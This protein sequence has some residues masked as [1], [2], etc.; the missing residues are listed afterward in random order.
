[1]AV[2]L[3]K[4]PYPYKALIGIHS[5]IDSTKYTDIT[6]IMRFLN[7]T[8]TTGLGTGIGLPFT[9]SVFGVSDASACSIFDHTTDGQSIESPGHIVDGELWTSKTLPKYIKIGWI[10]F[11]HTLCASANSAYTS[12]GKLNFSR[13]W[14][15]AYLEWV[16]T[17]GVVLPYWI[18]HSSSASNITANNDDRSNPSSAEYVV[19]LLVDAGIKYFEVGA[20]GTGRAYTALNTA[21]SILTAVDFQDG[22]K[23]WSFS[24]AYQTGPAADN[25]A[26]WCNET[27]LNAI[28]A[29]GVMDIIAIHWG[30]WYD[31]GAYTQNPD[32]LISS[33][34]I[35]ALQLLKTYY[36]A[37]NIL[38]AKTKD[39]LQYDLAKKVVEWSNV[40]DVITVTGFNDTQ[41]GSHT[42][43]VEE[44]RGLT[45]YVTE[46]ATAEIWIGSTQ[47]DEADIVRNSADSTGVQSIGI[48]WH[49]HHAVDYTQW[50]YFEVNSYFDKIP[51]SIDFDLPIIEVDET[52]S[53]SV[54]HYKDGVLIPKQQY[55][56]SWSASNA[57]ATITSSGVL[58]AVTAGMVKVT[59][60]V[61]GVSKSK[62]TFIPSK[63]FVSVVGVTVGDNILPLPTY[64]SSADVEKIGVQ[65]KD[66]VTYLEL[67]ETTNARASQLRIKT[68][69]GIRAIAG[70]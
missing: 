43:T 49:S 9:T 39:I 6:E 52:T 11:L 13:D 15:T 51:G 29:N 30:Y 3:R 68:P 48:K 36:D 40:G 54:R 23:A 65:G 25:I 19:D 58:T 61:N 18:N 33:A 17:Y 34:S 46:S 5:D 53:L 59:A 44:L 63:S 32:P 60:T 1:L 16:D 22:T 21:E 31:S 27:T 7:S 10:D 24:R 64:S 26:N 66:G 70:C 37:G 4:F 41:L 38:V 62:W 47:I 8:I 50:S 55:I 69:S 45:F 28:V 12:A 20:S 42:P 14:A 56:V 35:T 57:N 67:V 2:S